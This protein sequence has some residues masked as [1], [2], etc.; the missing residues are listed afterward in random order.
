MAIRISTEVISK[1]K[2]KSRNS[3]RAMARV[4]PK[5]LEAM[6]DSAELP[7]AA[8]QQP[9]HGAARATTPGT[10]RKSAILL[11]RVRSSAP[12]FQQHDHKD[13]QPMTAPA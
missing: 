3:R 12:A 13:K 10:P 9:A 6:T 7:A 8:H 11:P 5:V 1:G 4:S 2:R